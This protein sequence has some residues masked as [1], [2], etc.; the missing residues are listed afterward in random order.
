MEANITT[1]AIE[2]VAGVV[3]VGLVGLLALLF[4]WIRKNTKSDTVKSAIDLLEQAAT[5]TVGELQQTLVEGWKGANADGKLTDAEIE[6]LKRKSLSLVKSRIGPSAQEVITAAG[7]GLED[8]INA[9]VQAAITAMKNAN[10]V[11][12]SE[13]AIANMQ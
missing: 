1:T 8:R 3:E 9:A 5:D 13:A 11:V 4:T 10:V 6:A 12:L 2:V 7:I